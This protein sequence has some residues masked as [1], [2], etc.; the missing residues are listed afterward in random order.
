MI[1]FDLYLQVM[2]LEN[3]TKDRY[4]VVIDNVTIYFENHKFDIWIRGDKTTANI[5]QEDKE[6]GMVAQKINI[7]LEKAIADKKIKEDLEARERTLI[8]CNFL[9]D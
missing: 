8:I 5:K 4:K 3:A 9:E 7:L 1:N 6:Y 2:V